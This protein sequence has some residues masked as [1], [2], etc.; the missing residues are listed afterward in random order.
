MKN[1]ALDILLKK[2][3]AKKIL[4]CIK[5]GS[6]VLDIGCC[7]GLILDLLKERIKKGYGIDKLIRARKEGKIEFI[8]MD[9]E[10]KFP[11]ISADYIIMLA[12]IEHLNS[13]LNILKNAKKE[14]N[15]K[16]KIILT[17]PSPAA[18]FILET[19]ANLKLIDE[20][21]IKDHKQYFSEEKL[22]NILKSAGFK[23]IVTKKFQFG[24]NILA[25]GEK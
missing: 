5:N 11:R 22:R 15:K 21:E 6:I 12:L 24:F 2:W 23:N 25:I 17:T 10:K 18:K 16:G 4:K 7:D 14:L 20:N 3:R 9:L 19:L 8:R 13:P 1:T